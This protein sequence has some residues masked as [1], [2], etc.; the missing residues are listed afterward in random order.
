MADKPVRA[1]GANI[2]QLIGAA[3]V[4]YQRYSSS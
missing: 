3:T 2:V 1:F 4:R